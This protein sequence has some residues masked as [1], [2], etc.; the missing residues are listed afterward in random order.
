MR[1]IPKLWVAVLLVLAVLSG[2][3][4]ER[5]GRA[6]SWDNVAISYRV[7]GE[8]EP[9]LVFVHGWCCDKSYWKFQAAHFS[10]RHKVVTIDL[11]GHGKSGLGRKAW[12][13]EAFGKDVAAVVEKLD[14]DRVIL[15]G[16]S[17]GGAVIIEAARQMPE[18]VTGLVGAD[19]F[20]DLEKQYTREQIEQRVARFRANFVDE[21]SKLV[22][23]VF[24]PG[25]DPALVEWV[26]RDMSA[27][28]P[29]VGV[30][31]MEGYLSFDAKE[32]LKEVRKPIYCIN[33]VMRP[34]NVEAGRRYAAAFEVKLMSGVGHFLMLE[35]PEGF[36]RLL[37]E[38][39]NE[40]SR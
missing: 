23:G 4:R 6:L 14:L 31:A 10:K 35:D 19:T 16:H 27:G 28:P 32:A 3:G 39:I 40:L 5:E 30:G 13:M 11:G 36:N 20:L 38:T 7:Q 37:A 2:C 29:E 8:G 9:V 26:V 15:I 12:T 17:M 25:A 22:R 18:R 33:S 24:P 21:T 34:T 1:R